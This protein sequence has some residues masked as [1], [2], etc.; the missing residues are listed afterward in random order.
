MSGSHYDAVSSM[1]WH[2]VG[3]STQGNMMR[4]VRATH[5]NSRILLYSIWHFYE[6]SVSFSNYLSISFTM[7]VIESS[8]YCWCTLLCGSAVLIN[9]VLCT[10]FDAIYLI[11][12]FV[13]CD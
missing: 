4:R 12:E 3:N 1:S 9:N 11:I 8:I 2:Q 5:F 10:K 7:F 13:F 6:V